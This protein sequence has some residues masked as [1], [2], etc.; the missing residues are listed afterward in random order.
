MVDVPGVLTALGIQFRDRGGECWA[1]CP[2]PRHAERTPSWSMQADGQHHCFGC[3]WK[4]GPA[5]LVLCVI[6]LSG[7]RAAQ[8]WIAEKGLYLDTTTPLEVELV[9]VK[10]DEPVPMQVPVDARIGPLEGW[11]TPARRYAAKRG[12]TA[13]QVTR[14]GLGYA[15]GGYYANR[16]LLPTR[17]G[18]GILLNITGRAW[19]DTKRPKYK[20]ANELRGWDPRAVFGEQFWPEDPRNSTLVLVEGE[21]NALACERRGVACVGA[22]GGS[23]LVPG[24]LLKIERFRHI[25][26]AMDMDLAGE[27]IA[28]ALQAAFARR[29]SF[30][31]VQ[32]PDSRDPNDLEREEPM[33][34]DAVL[35][36]A[37]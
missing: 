1:K 30:G 22:L 23:N 20:N 26:I 11:V 12:L 5:E 35:Q 27:G 32:F 25:V 6:G 18:S 7:Y 2:H 37:A 24:Q 10:P 34:L 9:V 33:L 31:V 14:W 21:L 16:I 8:G 36:A 28:Q 13:A 3:H 17:S 4:G 29:R 15:T 19:S